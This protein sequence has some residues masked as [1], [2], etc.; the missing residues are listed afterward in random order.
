[1]ARPK[2]T[3]LDYFP[4][5]IDI[6]QDE[7]TVAIAGEF[8]LQGEMAI[9][10]LLCAIYRNGYFAEWNELM[11]FKLLTQLPGVA[12]ETLEQ[13]VAR[14][15]KW[16]FFDKDLFESHSILTSRGIQRRYFEAT[17][18]RRH[19]NDGLPWLLVDPPQKPQKEVSGE[20]TPVSNGKTTVL[21]KETPQSKVNKNKVNKEIKHSSC[22]TK[23]AASGRPAQQPP[24]V[25]EVKAFALR[26][27]LD[28]DAQRF[29]DYNTAR[30]WRA[31]GT[32]IVDWQAAARLW[33]S[34]RNTPH[35]PGAHPDQAA[36]A[37]EQRRREAE[38]EQRRRESELAASRAI[39]PD[40]WLQSR[41]FPPGTS[42]A[43]AILS[44]LPGH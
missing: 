34:H 15:A 38:R 9:I 19:P 36:Q 30:G 7:K 33:A 10:K 22:F 37:R 4:L 1:M 32:T 43:E 2:K 42:L 26:E 3:G 5:D 6:F 28:I 24:T 17:R 31:G 11:K 44:T 29:V 27:A 21:C 25:D 12:A 14:L 23:K 8:G 18:S 16:E 41:G 13:I 40:V 39:K 20:E 35:G